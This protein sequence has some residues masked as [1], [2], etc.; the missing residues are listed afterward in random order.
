MSNLSMALSLSQADHGPSSYQFIGG[1]MEGEEEGQERE[2]DEPEDVTSM[3]AASREQFQSTIYLS[4]PPTAHFQASSP[5]RD[6][7][8]PA[9]HEVVV[10]STDQPP[11]VVDEEHPFVLNV[12]AGGDV[13]GFSGSGRSPATLRQHS[14]TRYLPGMFHSGCLPDLLPQF[15]SW[16]LVCLGSYNSYNPTIGTYTSLLLF[17]Y[18]LVLD[19]SCFIIIINNVNEYVN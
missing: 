17:S 19:Q 15:P 6:E 7:G 18:W 12:S 9:P 3:F 13:V 8:D 11:S 5:E 2:E 4:P 10:S 1:Y 16:S 14:T